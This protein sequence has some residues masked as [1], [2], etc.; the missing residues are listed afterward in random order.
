MDDTDLELNKQFWPAASQNPVEVHV[1]LIGIGFLQGASPPLPDEHALWANLA[2]GVLRNCMDDVELAAGV[3]CLLLG[4]GGLVLVLGLQGSEL[5]EGGGNGKAVGRLISAG[6][7][8][9]LESL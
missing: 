6:I 3:T 9:W 7:Q 4:D 8:G 5:G 1:V 2:P